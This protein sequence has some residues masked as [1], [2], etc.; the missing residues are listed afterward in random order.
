M[1]F[2]PTTLFLVKTVLLLLLGILTSDKTFDLPLH[3]TYF[4]ISYLHLAIFVGFFTGLTTLIYY[5][6]ERFKRPIRLNT[7]LWH[8]GLFFVGL[9]LLTITI[10]LP[11]SINYLD[12]HIYI[13][14]VLLIIGIILLLTS[15]IV[16][17]YGLTIAIINK[18]Q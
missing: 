14:S 13:S 7:G 8:F 1:K 12:N 3:D 18:Q 11:T 10:N 17:L 2:K 4:V 5:G 9:I 16:F 6:L 15:V